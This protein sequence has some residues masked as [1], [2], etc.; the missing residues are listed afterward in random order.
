MHHQNLKWMSQI[1]GASLNLKTEEVPI[2]AYIFI[3]TKKHPKN[4]MPRAL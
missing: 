3:Q 2:Q 4:V 1:E